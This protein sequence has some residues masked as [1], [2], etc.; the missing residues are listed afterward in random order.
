MILQILIGLLCFQTKLNMY[1]GD[2]AF[3]N[4][5]Y[6]K[7]NPDIVLCYQINSKKYY[8]PTFGYLFLIIDFGA[9][10]KLNNDKY[11]FD[12]FNR[13]N[14]LVSD[15][16]KIFIRKILYNY[17][18]TDFLKIFLTKHTQ[19]I[20]KIYNNDKK[21]YLKNIRHYIKDIKNYNTILNYDELIYKGI[22]KNIIDIKI[23]IETHKDI[24]NIIHH[25]YNL[26]NFQNNEII[27]TDKIVFFEFSTIL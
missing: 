19:H 27:D 11:N 26:T 25:I 17:T 2:F 6:K 4:I 10:R 9:Y 18:L 3:R 21:I 5:L 22:H 16:E 8:I 24:L 1:H 20:K 7:I 23:I 12:L 14:S 13:I 15:L